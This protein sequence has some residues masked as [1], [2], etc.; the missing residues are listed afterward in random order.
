MQFNDIRSDMKSNGKS[1]TLG[2]LKWF[3]QTLKILVPS[4]FSSGNLSAWVFS[5][6]LLPPFGKSPWFTPW[7]T[8]HAPLEGF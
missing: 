6:S 4:N 8:S 2:R 3:I 7:E 1:R 5:V